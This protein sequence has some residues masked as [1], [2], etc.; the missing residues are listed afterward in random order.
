M[1]QTKQQVSAEYKSYVDRI[2]IPE[3]TD[4]QRKIFNRGAPADKK[5]ITKD[6]GL[7]VTGYVTGNRE[8]LEHV[9]EPII[10][11]H[12]KELS[13]RHPVE[14][15]NTLSLFSYEI[16]RLYFGKGTESWSYYR[17]GG[18]VLDLDDSQTRGHRFRYRYGLDCSGYASMPYELAVYFDLIAPEDEAA[19]FSSQGFE[20]YCKK[21]GI[22][23]KGGTGGTSNRY[24][25][26]TSDMQNL[27][28]EIMSVE[29]GG[30]PAFEDIRK[31]QAGDVVV[32][33]GHAGILVEIHGDL[34][35][36]EV[37]R[38]VIPPKGK[39]L[40]L[41]FSGLVQFARDYPLTVR[42]SLPD[43]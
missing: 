16:Y 18:D 2:E 21:H 40:T 30:I 32:G 11:P 42:R 37:G 5:T 6:N 25:V 23:D 34:F 17:W 4:E 19:V 10:T 39:T 28:R 38:T 8:F 13:S 7:T 14:I 3:P 43:Y 12:V 15:I 1:L 41:V 26:D 27:G 36:T 33:P 31:L 35:Y 20:I 24:R 29:K 22:A 9:I